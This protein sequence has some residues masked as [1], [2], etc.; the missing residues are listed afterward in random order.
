MP[1]TGCLLML[2]LYRLESCTHTCPG[3]S[4]DS[5]YENLVRKHMDRVRQHQQQQ[6]VGI[7]DSHSRGNMNKGLRRS[8]RLAAKRKL[9][10]QSQAQAH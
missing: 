10:A 9:E 1:F 8:Q 5:W 7:A 4:T 3:T 6:Q 2:V